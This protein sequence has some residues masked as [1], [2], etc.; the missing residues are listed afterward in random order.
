[1]TCSVLQE[2]PFRDGRTITI[3]FSPGVVDSP[4]IK[5]TEVGTYDYGR[6]SEDPGSRIMLSPAL[7][8]ARICDQADVPAFEEAQ[9]CIELAFP[10]HKSD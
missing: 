10:H 7:P 5:A 6:G 9:L 8:C 1:M 3:Q 2:V 4:Q